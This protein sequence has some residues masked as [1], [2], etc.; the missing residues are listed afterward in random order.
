M[1][2]IGVDIGGTNTRAAL[3]EVDLRASCVPVVGERVELPT[4]VSSPEA[5]LAV[6]FACIEALPWRGAAAIGVAAAIMVDAARGMVAHS[7]HLPLAGIV[8]RELLKTRYGVPVAIENDAISACIGEHRY[9]AARGVDDVVMLTLGTGVG[10]GIISAGRALRGHSGAAAELGHLSI[11]V[12]GP[13]CPGACPGRGCLEA[14]VS[15]RAMDAAARAV[16]AAEPASALGLAAASGQ[17]ADGPLLT[18]LA[19]AGDPAAAALIK[20]F[21]RSLGAGLV[22]LTNIFNPSLIVIGG[23]A[24][25]AGELLL[26]PARR[27]IAERATQPARDEVDVVGAALGADAGLFGAAALAAEL[28]ADRGRVGDG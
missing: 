23:A 26:A 15:G 6:L 1:I 11:D 7:V 2:V 8:L 28:A 25:A 18:R 24:A 14:Y 17:A 3:L 13:P 12:D 4:D 27:V 16:A 5:C 20:G 19:L 9:G 21:G 22:S 10:G